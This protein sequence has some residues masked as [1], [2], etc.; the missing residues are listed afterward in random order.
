MSNVN[1]RVQWLERELFY[2][3]TIQDCQVSSQSPLIRIAGMI[4]RRGYIPSAENAHFRS[5]TRACFNTVRPDMEANPTTP[6]TET[7]HV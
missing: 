6:A 2:D 7:M 3:K 5:S 4:L 1:G